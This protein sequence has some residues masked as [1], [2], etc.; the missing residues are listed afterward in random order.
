[1]KTF[2]LAYAFS[3]SAFHTLPEERRQIPSILGRP[4][5]SKDINWIRPAPRITMQFLLVFCTPP[6]YTGGP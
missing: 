4:F 1:M 5:Q 3:L 6:S 2:R